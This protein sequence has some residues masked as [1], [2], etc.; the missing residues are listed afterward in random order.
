MYLSRLILNS[1]Q[2]DVRRDLA[3]CQDLHRTV[4]SAFPQAHSDGRA[5]AEMGVLFRAELDPRSGRVT[6]LVQSGHEPEWSHLPA[7]YLLDTGG[8]PTNPAFKEVTACYSHLAEG[9]TLAF[10][11]R[12]NPTRKIATKSGPDG[13][14]RN[15]HRV[16]LRDEPAQLDWLRRRGEQGGFRLVSVRANAGVPNVTATRGDKL[17]GKRPVGSASKETARLTLAAVTFDGVLRITDAMKFRLALVRGIGPGK[18]FGF[19]LLS[20]A[21]LRGEMREVGGGT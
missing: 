21:P 13:Q 20:V 9:H 10:R 12:A 11:L 1:R 7:G 16:E 19:G 18:A 8:D 17:T 5:R 14:R 15:G 4:M 6:L 2:R 3:D